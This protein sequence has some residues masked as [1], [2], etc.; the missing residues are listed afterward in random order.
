[1]RAPPDCVLC[2]AASCPA[3]CASGQNL[4]GAAYRRV[5]RRARCVGSACR[6]PRATPAAAHPAVPAGS[7][8]SLPQS[9]KAAARSIRSRRAARLSRPSVPVTAKPLS[10]AAA[11]PA[12]SSIRMRSACIEAA[13][14]I[15]ARSPTSSA[16]SAGSSG[17][18]AGSTPSHAG[19]AAAQS[20]TARGASACVSSACTACG[21]DTRAESVRQRLR[22]CPVARDSADGPVSAATQARRVGKFGRPQDPADRGQ[23][24][25]PHVLGARRVPSGGVERRPCRDP[26]RRRSSSTVRRP[27]RSSATAKASQRPARRLRRAARQ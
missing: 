9:C 21:S 11:T 25:R 26:S 22:Y 8:N 3:E 17:V 12:R 1:M 10:R 14:V 5:K 7:G 23:V 13:S 27:A 24:V 16:D 6:M 18:G 2:C 15:V 4:P 19:G 20:R